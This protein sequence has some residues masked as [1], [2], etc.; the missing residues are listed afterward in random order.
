M[1][2]SKCEADHTTPWAQTGRTDA[3][4]GGPACGRHNKWKTLGYSIA[5]Q[6]DGTWRVLRPDGTSI[7]S[8]P[9]A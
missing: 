4:D 7:N 6:A 3:A 5:P 1:P 8:P 2:A 9:A